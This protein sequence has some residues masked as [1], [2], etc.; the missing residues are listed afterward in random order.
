MESVLKAAYSACGAAKRGGRHRIHV[1]R[2]DDAPSGHAR[3]AAYWG[4]LVEQALEQDGFELFFEPIAALDRGRAA[5]FRCE[6]LLR[7]RDAG[8]ALVGPDEFLPAAEQFH[9]STRID[10]W[11]VDKALSWLAGHVRKLPGLQL[12]T[13]NLSG[14]SLADDR[15]LAFALERV[16]STSLRPELICFEITETAAVSDIAKA[17]QFIGRLS[18]AGCRFALDDFG[19]GVSNFS[20]L[21]NLPVDFLKIDGSFVKDMLS[22]PLDRAMV[23]AINQIGQVLGKQTIAEFVQCDATID[24]L[25]RIGVDYAQGWYIGCARPL[26]GLLEAPRD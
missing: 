13:I 19:T 12:C 1:H 18:E 3:D 10:R 26:S 17:R 4:A 8:G 2:P 21:K 22:D 11:V 25:R 24:Q 20:Y 23:D 15:F 5:E 9:L 7:L 6:L 16:R 14:H